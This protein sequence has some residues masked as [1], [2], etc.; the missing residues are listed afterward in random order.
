MAKTAQQAFP[1]SMGVS[2]IAFDVR[3]QSD[4]TGT[5]SVP[6]AYPIRIR[7]APSDPV[8]DAKTP[9]QA[10]FLALQARGCR[11][12]P[13]RLHFNPA[14]VCRGAPRDPRGDTPSQPRP[15]VGPWEAGQF[16]WRGIR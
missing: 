15:R 7:F 6:V 13:G 3:A 9:L 10:D 11:F 12:D 14:L 2:L 8:P 16:P 5:P 1:S 4:R